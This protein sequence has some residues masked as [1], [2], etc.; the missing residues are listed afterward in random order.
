MSWL[1]WRPK[2]VWRPG[3][4]VTAL[5]VGP[6]YRQKDYDLWNDIYPATKVERDLE[7]AWNAAIAE[8]KARTD[9]AWRRQIQK[10]GFIGRIW[11]PTHSNYTERFRLLELHGFTL[12]YCIGKIIDPICPIHGVKNN[13][14]RRGPVYGEETAIDPSKHEFLVHYRWLDQPPSTVIFGFDRASG[15]DRSVSRDG[16]GEKRTPTPWDDGGPWEGK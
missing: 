6:H 8:D 4:L 14:R 3:P 9:Q 16:R 12:C 15:P 10:E 2:N 7:E 1:T 5:L 11:L 13:S